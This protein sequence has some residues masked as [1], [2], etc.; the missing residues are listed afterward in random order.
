MIQFLAFVLGL[1]GFTFLYLFRSFIATFYTNIP[2]LALE[3]AHYL[4]IVAFFYILNCQQSCLVGIARGL[5][6]YHLTNFLVFLTIY[7]LAA[8]LEWLFAFPMH[9]GQLGLWLGFS[10]GFILFIILMCTILIF[11]YDWQDIIRQTR[12]RKEK[13]ERYLQDIMMSTRLIDNSDNN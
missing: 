12:L 1:I 3:V 4:K 8:P 10:S 9:L 7:A 6:I 5:G 2:A 11:C 13:E